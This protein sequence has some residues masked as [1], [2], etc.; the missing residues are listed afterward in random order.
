MAS[1]LFF[2]QYECCLCNDYIPLN[3][4]IITTSSN[5]ITRNWIPISPE[6]AV[7]FLIIL[8]ATIMTHMAKH[9]K[10]VM[11]IIIACCCALI[12][13]VDLANNVNA[14]TALTIRIIA[15]T[16]TFFPDGF[17]SFPSF[18]LFTLITLNITKSISIAGHNSSPLMFLRP[19]CF[20][21]H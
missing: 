7:F 6:K 4:I 15:H 11:F 1:L 16:L 3:L 5:N 19:L 20:I 8:E 2:M 21:H 13:N 9:A 14:Y 17:F 12:E 10:Q 18:I